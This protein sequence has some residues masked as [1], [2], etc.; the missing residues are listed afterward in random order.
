MDKHTP[1]QR[2]F[3]MSQVKSTN[4]KP[5]IF[6]FSLLDMRGVKYEKHYKTYGRP[7]VAFPG[8]RIAVFINGEFW[9]GRNYN[10]EKDRYK[11]FWIEKIQKN[12]IRDKQ[13]Y[14]LLR[15]DG[16]T[17]IKIWDKDIKKFPKRELNKI[18]KALNIPLI[19]KSDLEI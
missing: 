8:K 14:K 15:K 1:E 7:D 5:E 17:V 10:K 12:I 11:D 16:W 3:N 19:R 2:S 13:N 9:H 6:I 18:M 4:T